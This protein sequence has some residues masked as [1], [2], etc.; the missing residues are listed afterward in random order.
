MKK[1]DIYKLAQRAVLRDSSLPEDVQLEI[2]RELQAE[3][4][5]ALWREECEEKENAEN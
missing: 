3:E 4:R 1:S 2:I 5:M